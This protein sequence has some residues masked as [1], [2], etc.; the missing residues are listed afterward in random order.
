MITFLLFF[1]I[2]VC[3]I[4]MSMCVCV[5]TY[6]IDLIRTSKACYIMVTLVVTLVLLFSNRNVYEVLVVI[7]LLTLSLYTFFLYLRKFAS[8]SS[9]VSVL[10]KNEYLQSLYFSF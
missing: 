6:L 1:T 3:M 4:H 9:L 5:C 2:Y 7:T 8:I 10:I